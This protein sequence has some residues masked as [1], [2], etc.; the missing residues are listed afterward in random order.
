VPNWMINIYIPDLFT[1]I[2]RFSILN[3]ICSVESMRELSDHE[4]ASTVSLLNMFHIRQD[5]VERFTWNTGKVISISID[6][7][8]RLVEALKS[9]DIYSI[10]RF[11]L[12]NRKLLVDSTIEQAKMVVEHI[13]GAPWSITKDKLVK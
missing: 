8:N 11:G 10:G 1:A 12:W 4:I 5:G 7:R 9:V 3:G 6:D 13:Y 2:Y